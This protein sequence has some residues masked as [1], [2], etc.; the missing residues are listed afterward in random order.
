MF[1]GGSFEKKPLN[2]ITWRK[3]FCIIPYP[4]A[5]CQ[6]VAPQMLLLGK[7]RCKPPPHEDL[8]QNLFLAHM[9]GS[10]PGGSPNV[11]SGAQD[12]P[13]CGSGFWGFQE[14]PRRFNLHCSQLEEALYAPDLEGRCL[15]F[16]YI[17]L[18]RTPLQDYAHSKDTEKR[19][20]ATR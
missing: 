2:D 17:L 1:L 18:A 11:D 7:V 10:S 14:M 12:L 5:I 6:Q 16:S 19:S 9:T 20:V 4:K 8:M 15:K 13:I 3:D